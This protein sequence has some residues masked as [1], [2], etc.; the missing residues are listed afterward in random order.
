MHATLR[1]AA[2]GALIGS[3]AVIGTFG[4]LVVVGL[5][6]VAPWVQM[7]NHFMGGT[8]EEWL[9]PALVGGLLFLVIGVLWGLPFYRIEEP[10]TFKGVIYGVLPTLWAWT[11]MPLLMDRPPL[12]NLDPIAVML[13][14]LMN[15]IIWG[16]ILGWW[17]ERAVF[18][19]N[20]A[21]V[22]Y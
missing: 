22:Y 8:A 14:V 6:R 3:L 9:I 19:G 1:D 18:G 7:W 21:S 10:S 15:C 5:V 11:G 16:S 13:P 12:G 4:L 20:S 17:C 2:I